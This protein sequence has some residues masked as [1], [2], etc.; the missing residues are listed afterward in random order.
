MDGWMDGWV[1][2]W[3]PNLPFESLVHVNK[4]SRV[5]PNSIFCKFKCKMLPITVL[6]IS[7]ILKS[8]SRYPNKAKESL[9]LTLD[10]HSHT[11][12]GNTGKQKS[13]YLEAGTFQNSQIVMQISVQ[14]SFVIPWTVAHQA[15][16]STGF[17][18]QEYWSGLPFP[19]PGD[20]PDPRIEL[21]SPTL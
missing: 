7:Q 6:A 2:V 12:S 13:W 21:G 3:F 5:W 17:S 10:D 19:S 16:L 14:D 18:G 8:T 4:T 11:S 1:I 9:C 20:L 15:P